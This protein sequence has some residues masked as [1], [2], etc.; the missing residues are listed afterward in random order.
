MYRQRWSAKV[1]VRIYLLLSLVAWAGGLYLLTMQHNEV[2]RRVEQRALDVAL[3]TAEQTRITLGNA[4]AGLDALVGRLRSTDWWVVNDQS[5]VAAE[6]QALL[7]QTLAQ[8]EQTS[9]VPLT[10]AIADAKGVIRVWR[11][12]PDRPLDNLPEQALKDLKTARPDRLLVTIGMLNPHVLPSPAPQ[13]AGIPVALMMRRFLLPN[14]EFGGVAIAAISLRALAEI[15]QPVLHGVDDRLML[16]DSDQRVLVTLSKD[17]LNRLVVQDATQDQAINLATRPALIPNDG[18]GQRLSSAQDAEG[19]M[20]IYASHR[21]ASMGMVSVVDMNLKDA[22]AEWRQQ[23]AWAMGVAGSLFFL[24]TLSVF[25]LL[26]QMREIASSNAALHDTQNRLVTFFEGAQEG[27]VVSERGYIVDVNRAFEHLTGLQASELRGKALLSLVHP[28]DIDIA[29]GSLS[30]EL[31][32]PARLRAR[33]ADG[34]W[35]VL[36]VQGKTLPGNSAVRLSTA[37][38]ISHIVEQEVQLTALVNDLQRSNRDLEQFA[39]VASHDLQEPLRTIAS[40]V[41]LLDRRCRESLSGEGREFMDYIVAGA[42]RMQALIRDLLAYSRVGT[43]GHDMVPHDANKLLGEALESLSVV[44]AD[45][46]ATVTA[47]PL[48]WVVADHVQISRLFQNLLSNAIKYRQPERPCEIFITV[49]AGA[50]DTSQWLFSVRDNG[51]GIAPQFAE[52]VFVIFQRLHG[53]GRYEGTGIG[54][55]VARRIVERH[56]GRIWVNTD[57]SGPGTEVCFT[58]ARASA[59]VPAVKVLQVG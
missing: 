55:A 35:L 21:V 2:R 9:V 18:S 57:Y 20:R 46:G 40:Y 38:D 28:E 12:D 14:G 19:A 37:H 58:L 30:H 7:S 52:Q 29:I 3:L 13:S 1:Y 36:E 47:E 34:T 31:A 53:I 8:M 59:G 24:L 10:Y 5:G 17:S 15:Y 26:R 6:Q 48:P 42:L 56:G 45:S 49:Q 27:I 54:L 11:G 33:R 39:Y 51:I 32:T 41:G 16:I 22:F 4:S 23:T 43:Q 50:L 44:I 25:T